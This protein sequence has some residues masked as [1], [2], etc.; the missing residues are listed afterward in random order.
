[1]GRKREKKRAW[2]RRIQDNGRGRRKAKVFNGFVRY[3]KTGE[4]ERMFP[5]AR[6]RENERREERKGGRVVGENTDG[7]VSNIMAVTITNTYKD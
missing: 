5:R 3:I 2:E 6:E 1:M 7:V 4:G